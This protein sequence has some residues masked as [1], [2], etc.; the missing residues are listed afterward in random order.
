SP[1]RLR[2][3]GAETALEKGIVR[4]VDPGQA[5]NQARQALAQL[6]QGRESLVAGRAERVERG[7]VG[8]MV[9]AR[10]APALGRVDVRHGD[11]FTSLDVGIGG[12]RG[13]LISM[14]AICCRLCTISCRRTSPRSSPGRT[15]GWPLSS[16]LRRRSV[17]RRNPMSLAKRNGV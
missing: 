10:H 6:T 7:I 12:L 15:D 17:S 11:A 13:A 16:T 4:R 8:V 1:S 9:G 14:P 5:G 2:E 3:P